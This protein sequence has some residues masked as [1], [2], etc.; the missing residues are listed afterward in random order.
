MG[1][2]VFDSGQQTTNHVPPLA[3]PCHTLA[4]IIDDPSNANPKRCIFKSEGHRDM[5]VDLYHSYWQAAFIISSLAA[6]KPLP[7]NQKQYPSNR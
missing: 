3:L 5:A 4:T 7:T 2:G 1:L 6:V